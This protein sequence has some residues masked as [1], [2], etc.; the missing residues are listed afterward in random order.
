MYVL[1]T[2]EFGLEFRAMNSEEFW[3]TV[4]MKREDYCLIEC[5]IPMGDEWCGLL[6]YRRWGESVKQ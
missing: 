6:V 5:R 1:Y 3:K 4:N 2:P